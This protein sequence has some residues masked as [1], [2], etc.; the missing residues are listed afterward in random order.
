MVARLFRLGYEKDKA[1][2]RLGAS[3]LLNWR[4]IPA[5]V[6]DMIITQA[7]AM[8]N[9]DTDVRAEIERLTGETPR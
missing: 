4:Q 3:T 1:L 7:L 8:S 5:H 6:Q 2:Q 9:D